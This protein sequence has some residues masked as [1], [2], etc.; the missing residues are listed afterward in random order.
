MNLMSDIYK[1]VQIEPHLTPLTSGEHLLKRSIEND[2]A[3]L[4]ISARSFWIRGQ[5][6]YFDVRVFNPFAKKHLD[7]LLR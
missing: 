5:K 3:R 1:D 2:E 7:H 4:D 6:A